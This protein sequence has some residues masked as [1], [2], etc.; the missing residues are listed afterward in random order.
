[1]VGDL[2]PLREGAWNVVWLSKQR[3]RHLEMPHIQPLWA[4]NLIEARENR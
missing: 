2:L 1:M 3:F 4:G